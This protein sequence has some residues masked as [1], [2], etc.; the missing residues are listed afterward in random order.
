MGAEA[1]ADEE[2]AEEP[3]GVGGED[4]EGG[5]FEG[6]LGDDRAEEEDVGERTAVPEGVWSGGARRGGGGTREGGSVEECIGEQYAVC[7]L[8]V[9]I[10]VCVCIVIG[11]L[12]GGAEA[13]ASVRGVFGRLAHVYS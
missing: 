2:D 7:V 1:A 10:C 11:R 6:A 3:G 12:R 8:C 5:E 13:S 4:G 9:Y